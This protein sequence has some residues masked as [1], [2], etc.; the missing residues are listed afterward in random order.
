MCLNTRK[1]VIKDKKKRKKNLGGFECHR[2]HGNGI[3]SMVRL[4]ALVDL[5]YK[6]TRP[7]MILVGLI[8]VSTFN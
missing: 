6:F 4:A 2:F 8:L 7:A 1:L 5:L 3:L